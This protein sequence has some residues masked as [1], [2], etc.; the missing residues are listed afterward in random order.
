MVGWIGSI[1]E[2][3]LGQNGKMGG[4]YYEDKLGQNGRLGGWYL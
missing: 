2:D 1:H 3:K 4:G